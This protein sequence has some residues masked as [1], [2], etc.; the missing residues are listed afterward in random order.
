MELDSKGDAVAVLNR[1]VCIIV[2]GKL[3][4]VI[5]KCHLNAPSLNLTKRSYRDI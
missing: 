1:N 4:A 5:E 2:K 3:D